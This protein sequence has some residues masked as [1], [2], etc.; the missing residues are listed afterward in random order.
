MSDTDSISYEG[1]LDV[2]R[3]ITAHAEAKRSGRDDGERPSLF[4][5]GG[6]LRGA[7]GAGSLLA[8]DEAGLRNAFESA[9]GISTGAPSLAYFLAGQ[10][11]RVDIYYEEGTNPNLFDY[12]G[13][14]KGRHIINTRFLADLLRGTFG[15]KK[16][17][18][19]KMC[20][21]STRLYVPLAEYETAK[22]HMCELHET[23]DPVEA[24]HAAISMPF[25][26]HPVDIDGTA[27]V[28]GG[29]TDPFPLQQMIEREHPTCILVLANSPRGW[30]YPWA[31]LVAR[32]I[33][34]FFLPSVLSARMEKA[35]VSYHELFEELRK[36]NIPYLI[37]WGDTEVGA[38]TR[39]ANVLE[40]AIERAKL[41]TH[42]LVR[43]AIS[44]SK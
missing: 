6:M 20:E 40:S 23:K 29:V 1:D 18:T 12:W 14:F 11:E 35:F 21:S 32:F 10:P 28:D 16:L 2:L 42:E 39:V 25:F 26:S 4:V 36:S 44:L 30:H 19:G 5:L 9:L 33:S 15:K 22:L 17:D 27:Y 13:P 41:Y 34:R 7:Y 24:I 31:Y 8:L 37:I 43:K 38:F 3:R